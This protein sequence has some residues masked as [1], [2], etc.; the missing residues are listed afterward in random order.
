MT[1]LSGGCLMGVA[2]WQWHQSSQTMRERDR[3]IS[4]ARQDLALLNAPKEMPLSPKKASAE[5]AAKLLQQ[6]LNKVFSTIE[7][8]KE[9]GVRLRSLSLDGSSSV[10][11]LEFE[12][13][14]V[15]KATALT[16]VLNAGYDGRPWQL[17]GVS[18]A[19][20]NNAMGFATTQTVRAIWFV[21]LGKL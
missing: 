18:S 7:V 5:Q 21:E 3:L 20:N 13:D 1:L 11:R 16:A 15:A 14:S 19:G 6:D 9:P 8:L 4:I 10:V 2:G 12:I 17:E